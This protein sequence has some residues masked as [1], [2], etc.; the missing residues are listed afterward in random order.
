MPTSALFGERTFRVEGRSP[1]FMLS[2][3]FRSRILAL[4]LP[5]E[6]NSSS[7]VGPEDSS[8]A[9]EKYYFRPYRTEAKWMCTFKNI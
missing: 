6:P 3:E 8:E 1:S 2:G 4:P 7:D 9:K 5:V